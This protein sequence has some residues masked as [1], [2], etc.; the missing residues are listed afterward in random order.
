MDTKNGHISKGVTF[1]PSF[2]VSMYNTNWP[3]PKWWNLLKHHFIL[4]TTSSVEI[5]YQ[6]SLKAEA[7]PAEKLSYPRGNRVPTTNSSEEYHYS[8]PKSRKLSEPKRFLT[9]NIIQRFGA[10]GGFQPIP[11][12]PQFEIHQKIGGNSKSEVEKAPSQSAIPAPN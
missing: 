1:S 4:N 9:S 2:W 3:S 6:Y 7:A 5:R 12:N 8:L 10:S 11:G